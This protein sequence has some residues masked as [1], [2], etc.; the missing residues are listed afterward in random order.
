MDGGYQK[1]G[2]EKGKELVVIN[3]DGTHQTV[4]AEEKGEYFE[5]VKTFHLN[6]FKIK[7]LILKCSAN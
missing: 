2:K 5:I 1:A 7:C 4:L 6:R 3:I